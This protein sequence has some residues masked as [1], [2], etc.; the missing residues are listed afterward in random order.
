MPKR[1]VDLG[2]NFREIIE[3]CKMV[4]AAPESIVGFR[5]TI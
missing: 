5:L 4:T 1:L 3:E 2:I